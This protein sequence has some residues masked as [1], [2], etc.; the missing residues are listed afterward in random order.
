[1]F[2]I[3]DIHYLKHIILQNIN[4]IQKNLGTDHYY[5]PQLELPSS[6]TLQYEL[7]LPPAYTLPYAFALAFRPEMLQLK[8]EEKTC[9]LISGLPK[10]GTINFQ[11]SFSPRLSLVEILFSFILISFL[12][13]FILSFILF[14]SDDFSPCL[15]F[16]M[17]VRHKLGL[18]PRHSSF[19]IKNDGLK[20]LRWLGTEHY[21][22]VQ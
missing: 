16:A 9:H 2:S 12:L 8:L 18:C 21:H 17:L 15:H 7:S 5:Q 14:L 10:N 4:S 19:F 6:Y 3:Y 11:R 20:I 1:M 22:Q 13:A